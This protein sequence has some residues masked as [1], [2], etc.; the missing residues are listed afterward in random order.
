[1]AIVKRVLQLLPGVPFEFLRNRHV[2]RAFER[3]RVDDVGDH[4]LKLT[5][6]VFVQQRDQRLPGEGVGFVCHRS[7]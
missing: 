4:G 6:Q 2:L 3:L 7:S 5:R 1:L